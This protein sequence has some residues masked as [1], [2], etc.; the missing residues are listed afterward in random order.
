ML[1]NAGRAVVNEG[2]GG[3]PLNLAPRAPFPFCVASSSSV[4]HQVLR[5]MRSFRADHGQGRLGICRSFLI[6]H[7]H[8][9]IAGENFTS[10]DAMPDQERETVVQTAFAESDQRA[11]MRMDNTR[12][13]RGIQWHL[14]EKRPTRR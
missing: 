14:A 6:A 3:P 10:N 13:I 2:P 7:S 11:R 5:E 4:L 8:E 9:I 1:P 12:R